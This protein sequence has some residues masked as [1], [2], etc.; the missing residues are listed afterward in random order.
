MTSQNQTEA[1][2]HI[3]HLNIVSQLWYINESSV[4]VLVY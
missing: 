3:A 1:V 2:G 4:F